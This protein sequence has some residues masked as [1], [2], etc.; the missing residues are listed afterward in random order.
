MLPTVS[1]IRALTITGIIVLSALLGLT[2]VDSTATTNGVHF[3]QYEYE[4]AQGDIVE[5]GIFVEE[6]E[7]RTVTLH[8]VDDSDAEEDPIATIELEDTNSDGDLRFHISPHENENKAFSAPNGTELTV[9]VHRNGSLEPGEYELHSPG[10]WPAELTVTKP[11]INAIST[12]HASSSW[13]ANLGYGSVHESL[14]AFEEAKAN[15]TVV[16][17]RTDDHLWWTVTGAPAASYEDAL[18]IRI[19]ATGLEGVYRDGEGENPLQ[20]LGEHLGETEAWESQTPEQLSV[21][22]LQ[23]STSPET[24]PAEIDPFD[25]NATALL[26]DPTNGT[27]VLAIDLSDDEPLYPKG[28]N[29]DYIS[30]F[31]EFEIE[32]QLDCE[33]D[34]SCA[35]TTTEMTHLAWADAR[36]VDVEIRDDDAVVRGTTTL[37]PWETVTIVGGAEPVDA[38]VTL[39]DNG[40]ATFEAM[41]ENVSEES[42]LR[43]EYKGDELAEEQIGDLTP[44]PDPTPTSTTAETSS[45]TTKETPMTTEPT[46]AD[47]IPGFGVVAALVALVLALVFARR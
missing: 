34:D 26:A 28:H 38:T 19:E 21:E 46:Q 24:L 11:E 3:D 15:G 10:S 6:G 22:Q 30:D 17:Q 27:Y 8:D 23:S 44:T 39:T 1:P 40:T 14:N 43:I 37:G 45:P 25:A 42:V 9:T 32:L 29:Q 33:S 16:D 4:V 18:V 35:T 7:N 36:F 20:R 5:I 2:V 47:E 41:V 31:G 12:Y 13:V